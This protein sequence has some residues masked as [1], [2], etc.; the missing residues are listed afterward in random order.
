MCFEKNEFQFKI[1]NI[2]THNV[3]VLT[4]DCYL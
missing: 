1:L 4:V 3:H 2:D